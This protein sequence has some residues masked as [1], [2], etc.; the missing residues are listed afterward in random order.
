M[1]DLVALQN[2]KH[3]E[4]QW[5]LCHIPSCVPPP[6]ICH[7]SLFLRAE[8]RGLH[9]ITMLSVYKLFCSSLL[10]GGLLA[11]GAAGAEAVDPCMT[12]R[13]YGVAHGPPL[14]NK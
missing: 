3:A 5:P 6:I 4:H 1:S 10:V 11:V 2:A 9:L 7:T 12:R 8:Q 13:P 14:I